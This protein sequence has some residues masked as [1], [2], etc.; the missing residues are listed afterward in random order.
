MAI[1]KA[2]KSLYNEYIK[3]FKTEKDQAYGKIAD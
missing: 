3:D 1:T 2:E